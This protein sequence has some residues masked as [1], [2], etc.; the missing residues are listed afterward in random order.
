MLWLTWKLVARPALAA[1]A[2]VVASQAT[3]PVLAAAVVV[4]AH[5]A[6]GL[7]AALLGVSHHPSISQEQQAQHED[8]H[9]QGCSFHGRHIY[10]ASL[11]V[12][13]FIDKLGCLE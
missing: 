9:G 13:D 6:T 1:G 4:G 11:Y 10:I 7:A 8:L 2:A 12:D 5:G 3:V